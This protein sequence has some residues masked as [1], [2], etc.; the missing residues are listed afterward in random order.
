[1]TAATPVEAQQDR[2]AQL[3]A[4]ARCPCCRYVVPFPRADIGVEPLGSCTACRRPRVLSEAPAEGETAAW[5]EQEE[6]C[7]HYVTET[8]R[9]RARDETLAAE[10]RRSRFKVIPGG[11]S[12][13]RKRRSG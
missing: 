2:R 10:G 11:K 8:Q 7:P 5:R 13:G 1:M 3:W 4:G 6:I 9:K 12:A